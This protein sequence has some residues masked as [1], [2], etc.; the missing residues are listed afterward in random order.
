MS[1]QPL[2]ILAFSGSLREGSFNTAVLRE[3]STLVPAGVVL[4]I[5]D[6]GDLPLYNADLGQVPA[7][8]ALK[9]KVAAADAVL[10]ATPEY[11]YSIPGPLKNMLDWLS[12]P[13]FESVFAHKPV[14]VLSVSPGATGAVRAQAHLKNVLLAMVAQVFPHAEVGIGLAKQ[15]IEDGK[16]SQEDTRALLK[17]FVG[18]FVTYV[19]EG[20]REAV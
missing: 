12:R 2:N 10:I 8:L 18:K 6:Y 17:D 3:L 13:A 4:Q 1:E 9:A 20:R 15:R 11:N 14:A 5:A 19:R 16:V 7:V